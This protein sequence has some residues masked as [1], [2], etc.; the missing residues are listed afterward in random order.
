MINERVKSP[1]TNYEKNFL[2][3]PHMQSLSFENEISPED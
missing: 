2:K 3:D 1:S